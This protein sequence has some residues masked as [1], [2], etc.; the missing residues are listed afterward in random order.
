MWWEQNFEKT[1]KPLVP[2]KR[3]K[4]PVCKTNFGLIK[5]GDFVEF[6]CDECRATFLFEPG[7]KLP[8]AK[9]DSAVKSCHCF[10]CLA[11]RHEDEEIKDL[12]TPP[13]DEG[14]E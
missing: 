11:R 5:Q 13:V 14:Y 8:S 7:K 9:M 2:V 1:T 6:H 4:C 12:P 10:S 3:A